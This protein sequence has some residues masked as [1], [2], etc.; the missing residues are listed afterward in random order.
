LFHLLPLPISFMVKLVYLLISLTLSGLAQGAETCWRENGCQRIS[1]VGH[2]FVT[3]DENRPL[4]QRHLLAIR[5]AKLDALRALAEQVKGIHLITLSQLEEARLRTDLV[6]TR[7]QT[8]LQGVRYV[9]VEP[10][11]NDLY[12]AVVEIDINH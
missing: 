10:I 3:P 9:S 6:S 1:G 4:A 7:Q 11:G 5:A 2:G 12:R 8:L